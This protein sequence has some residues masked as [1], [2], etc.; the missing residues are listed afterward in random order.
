MIKMKFLNQSINCTIILLIIIILFLPVNFILSSTLYSND[1][2]YLVDYQSSKN[3]ILNNENYLKHFKLATEYFDNFSYQRALSHYDKAYTLISVNEIKEQLNKKLFIT[4]KLLTLKKRIQKVYQLQC[5]ITNHKKLHSQITIFFSRHFNQFEDK[6]KKHKNYLFALTWYYF[7]KCRSESYMI[8]DAKENLY[9]ALKNAKYAKANKLEDLIVKDLQ[10]LNIEEQ[11]STEKSTTKKHNKSKTKIHTL[12]NVKEITQNHTKFKESN[13][14]TNKKIKPDQK[15]IFKQAVNLLHNFHYKDAVE[16]FEKLN[17]NDYGNLSKE[18]LLLEEKDSQNIRKEINR[19]QQKYSKIFDNKQASSHRRHL[20]FVVKLRNAQKFYKNGNIKRAKFFIEAA[21]FLAETSNE[22]E[23]VQHIAGKMN[24]NDSEKQENEDTKYIKSYSQ[25]ENLFNNYSYQ[26][27]L[28]QY[29]TA[30]TFT[31]NQFAK[32]IIYKKILLTQD[33]LNLINDM[34]MKYQN[35]CNDTIRHSFEKIITK[36]IY[37][38]S[39]ELNYDT[40]IKHSNNLFALNWYYFAQCRYLIKKFDEAIENYNNAF[41]FSKYANS[42]NLIAKIIKEKGSTELSKLAAEKKDN[43]NKK[44]L[45]NISKNNINHPADIKKILL[46]C[47]NINTKEIKKTKKRLTLIYQDYTKIKN[48]SKLI[49]NTDFLSH[50]HTISLSF[51]KDN[52]RAD[53]ILLYQTVCTMKKYCNTRVCKKYIDLIEK[54][55]LNDYIY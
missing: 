39:K 3:D 10:S 42:K 6:Q 5:N 33:F 49:N 38:R 30:Y 2:K 47:E 48:K 18:L 55:I 34:R 11:L 17:Q 37:S 26:N 45:P 16:Q 13:A 12:K 46:K 14:D 36:F 21:D 50:L 20:R 51:D 19:L 27:A 15:S 29:E 44:Q 43:I 23:Q 1:K 32:Y 25:A 9:F 4:D 53:M 24:L 22:K 8:N 31:S 41:K 54:R 28:E 40:I 35:L 52:G 7:A